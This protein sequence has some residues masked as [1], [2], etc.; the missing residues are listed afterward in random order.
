MKTLSIITLSFFSMTATFAADSSA[1][2]LPQ[3]QNVMAYNAKVNNF[4]HKCFYQVTKEVLIQAQDG[5][6]AI[7]EATTGR[8]PKDYVA[9]EGYD[10]QKVREINDGTTRN[11]LRA[12]SSKNGV[13]CCPLKN[14]WEKTA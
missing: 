4:S 10:F 8:C 7:D 14:T 11:V 13:L 1:P 2:I 5:V 6:G 3:A 9:M 12:V